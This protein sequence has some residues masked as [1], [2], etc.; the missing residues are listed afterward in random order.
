[1]ASTQ[2]PQE[3]VDLIVDNLHDD[4][5]TPLVHELHIVLV[6]SETSYES[7]EEGEHLTEPRVSW[8]MAERTLSLVLPL[9]DLKRISLVENSSADWTRRQFS[10]D[11]NTLSVHLRGIVVQSPYWLLS[12]F[13]KATFLKELSLSHVW[14]TQ[15]H[16]E[17][18]PWP[19]SQP[20]RPQLQSIL[21]ADTIGH[22]FC[23][24][25]LNPQID[26]TRLRSL[27]L[28]TKTR[29]LEDE[30]LQVANS[31]GV[32]HLRV[33]RT[34]ISYSLTPLFG[35]HL[36]SIHIFTAEIFTLLAV[37]FKACPHDTH[38][39]TFILEGPV[40]LPHSEQGLDI[41]VDATVVQL[42]HFER[43]EIKV[44]IHVAFTSFSA[45]SAVVRSSL[46]S[47]VKRGMLTLTEIQFSEVNAHH[48]W[49]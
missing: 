29:E 24:C 40:D 4:I 34:D 25:M 42:R 22:S 47:L 20:W 6:G 11:W 5:P 26:L 9:L 21:V 28:V 12:L 39:E 15:P 19:Q 13:S 1:M 14:F 16:D 43:V 45:W 7:E 36:R 8:I 18:K 44:N 2:L 38:I 41:S 30:M 32:E 33:W 3:L 35:A 48:G 23:G 49:E 27:T 46:P 10:M 37:L 17:H 31:S